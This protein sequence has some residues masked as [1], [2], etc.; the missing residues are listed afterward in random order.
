MQQIIVKIWILRLSQNTRLMLLSA[1]TEPTFDWSSWKNGLVNDH[2]AKICNRV[3][4]RIFKELRAM[5]LFESAQGLAP[6]NVHHK[7]ETN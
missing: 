1:P 4:M 7:Y 5:L 3:N 6:I 2:N